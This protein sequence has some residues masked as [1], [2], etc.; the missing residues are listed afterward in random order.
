MLALAAQGATDLGVEMLTTVVRG[1]A[2]TAAFSGVALGLA[3]PASADT[4]DGTYAGTVIDAAGPITV[5]LSPCGLDCVHFQV[6]GGAAAADLHR[7]GD[8]WAGTQ[9]FADGLNNAY[10]LH[11][12]L[13]LESRTSTP[14]TAVSSSWQLTKNP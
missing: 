1:L 6:V 10:T 3:C 8:R 14:A 11:D 4:P 12:S 2:I 13:V 7:Q 5:T 9:A